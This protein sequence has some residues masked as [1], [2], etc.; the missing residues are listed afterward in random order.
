VIGADGITLDLNGHSI[1]GDGALA[2]DCPSD[3]PCDAGILSVGHSRFT[4]KGG[5]ITDFGAGILLNGGT[6]DNLRQLSVDSNYFDGVLVF[7]SV[8]LTAEGNA[9]TRNGLIPHFVGMAMFGLSGALIRNNRLS[10]NGDLDLLLE[11]S[12]NR[13]RIVGNT[14]SGNSE[15]GMAVG[16]NGNDVS[17][18]RVMGGAINLVGDDNILRN[19]YVA[20]MGLSLEGGTGNSLTGNIVERA[21]V[22]GIRVNSYE[23][24]TP[25][26]VNNVV[27]GNI[28]RSA[29]VD[30]IAI[31]T[32]GPGRVTGTVVQDNLVVGSGDDGIDVESPST[33]VRGNVAVHN[34]DLGIE[35]VSGVT[36][37]GSNRAYA[38]G[39]SLQCTNIQCRGG[40]AGR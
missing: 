19:N 34:G 1:A 23:P 36:D 28:V 9:I 25:A 24:D 13:N 38:N 17:G 8:H 10:G 3:L 7:G 22:D 18:N 14:F 37:G 16:G 27:R 30:G 35:A 20:G 5:S 2:Q 6:D 15:S 33:T 39:N 11:D 31:A 12:S 4:V 21:A 32:D 26:A 40:R 29:G